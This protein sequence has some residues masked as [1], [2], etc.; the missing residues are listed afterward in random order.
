[1]TSRQLGWGRAP[2]LLA[3]E[4]TAKASE[5]LARE[6][7]VKQSREKK[8]AETYKNIRKKYILSLRRESNLYSC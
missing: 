1:V 7:L 6:D 8:I 3:G 4:K 5:Q 2:S